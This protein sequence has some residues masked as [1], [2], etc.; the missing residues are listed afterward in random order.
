MK[1]RFLM[2]GII[3]IATFVAPLVWFDQAYAS[4]V[5]ENEINW[6]V[7]LS[8]SELDFVGTVYSFN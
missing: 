8:E 4:C 2:I 3:V 1:T 5:A 6:N 7:V